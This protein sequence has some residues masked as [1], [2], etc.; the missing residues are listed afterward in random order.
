MVTFRKRKVT[1][2]EAL[3]SVLSYTY[4]LILTLALQY[5][6]RYSFYKWGHGVSENSCDFSLSYSGLNGREKAD[7]GLS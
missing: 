2:A 3:R 1:Y 4:H 7:S 5:T 6:Y